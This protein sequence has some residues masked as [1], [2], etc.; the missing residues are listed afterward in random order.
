MRVLLDS[1]TLL[2][3][4][5]DDPR[6]SR[7]AARVLDDPAT[8]PFVSAASAYELCYKHALGKLPKAAR[9]VSAFTDELAAADCAPLPITVEHARAAA[10]LAASHRDPFD[11]LLIAQALVERVPIVSNDAVFDGFGVKRVW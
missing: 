11:R 6:L 9:L 7:K 1:H 8:R 10:A 5:T 3:M 4:L 2:W